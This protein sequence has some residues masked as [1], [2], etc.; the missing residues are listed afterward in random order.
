MKVQALFILALLIVNFSH[1]QKLK[2]SYYG[3]SSDSLHNGHQLVFT[4]DTTLEISTFPRHMSKQFMMTFNYK[5]IRD[6]I[7]IISNIIL[8]A[9]SIALT[10]HC[11]TQ[12]L[13]N[14]TISKDKRAL[15][16]ASSKMVYVLYK[17]FRRHYLTYIIDSKIYKQET[18]LSDAYGIIRNNPKENKALKEKLSSLNDLGNYTINAYKGLEAYE[19]FGYD[20]V[21][22][23]IVLKQKE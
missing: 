18:G 8:P 12:F 15:V 13:N 3:V 11:L 9:D 22:G 1:G 6:K 7:E 21:F 5:R 4:T 17:D 14:I 23:V 2:Q 16:D 20:N 19:K 10:N